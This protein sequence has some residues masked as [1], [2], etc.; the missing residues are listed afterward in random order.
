MG[1]LARRG[2][3]TAEAAEDFLSPSPRCAYDPDLLP[4]LPAAV[5]KILQAA[6]YLL[7]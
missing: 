6:G 4:D 1:I 7:Q 5:T 2:I 3:S